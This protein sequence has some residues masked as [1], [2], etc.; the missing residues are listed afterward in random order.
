VAASAVAGI[1]WTVFSPSVAFTYL[2]VSMLLA[3]LG[4]A[5]TARRMGRPGAAP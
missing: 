1:L 4:L 2:A 3:L 5:D